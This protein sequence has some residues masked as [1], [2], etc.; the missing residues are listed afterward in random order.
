MKN[1]HYQNQYILSIKDF[2]ENCFGFIY[3]ITNTESNKIYIGKKYLFHTTKK[4]YTLT[5]KAENKKKNIWKEYKYVTKESDWLKYYG[6]SK[7]LIA[8]IKNQGYDY[9]DRE[10][11]KFCFSKKSLTYWEIYFQF[12]YD[13]LST[14]NYNDN[15][16]GKFFKEDLAI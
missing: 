8:D 15:I 2:P 10:I 1:W 13:V 6:S 9:F 4:K 12:K 14:D 3:K 11:I 16:L 5:E 7:S